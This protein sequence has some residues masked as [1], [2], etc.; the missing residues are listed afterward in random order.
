[1]QNDIGKQV[2]SPWLPR[3]TTRW[4]DVTTTLAD[5][6]IITF[7]VEPARLAALL[8]RD[9]APEVVTL[10]DGRQRALVSAVPF[11]DLDFRF[12]F[13]PWLRFRFG[14]T[15]YRAYVRYRGRRCVW[16]FGT[17][18]ATFWV[19]I[20][21]YGWK[22]PWHRDRIQIAASWDQEHCQRYQVATTGNWGQAEVEMEG[23]DEPTGTLDG[24]ANEE[25]TAVVLTHPL[26]GYFR[27]RDGRLG[28]YSVW[29]K[30]LEM[31]RGIA[32]KAEF[33]VFKDLGLV[34][35]GTTPHSVLLQRETEF[36]I[37]LPP[38]PLDE[39]TP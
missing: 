18:L 33:A 34:T 28:T 25:D 3:P 13:A 35:P 39:S 24:F 36:I 10:A 32:K 14:Q 15:N 2:T 20:P 9:F 8:P 38:K 19:L 31:C 27:R 17:S 37:V 29:H 12:G 5:F 4:C 16:F 21:R 30:R 23:T 1:M 7:D 6:A 11:R 22:L 26:A